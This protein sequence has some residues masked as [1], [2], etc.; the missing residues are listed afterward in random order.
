MK[1]AIRG[2]KAPFISQGTYLD[3][4][5]EHFG[6]PFW[7][8]IK[9]FETFPLSISMFPFSKKM[10]GALTKLKAPFILQGAYLEKDMFLFGFCLFV[11]LQSSNPKPNNNPSPDEYTYVSTLVL[12][13]I[14]SESFKQEN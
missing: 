3:T 11:C 7:E 4:I 8:K 13:Y 10:E 12:G 2:L 1:G 9:D 5:F 14:V 6:L